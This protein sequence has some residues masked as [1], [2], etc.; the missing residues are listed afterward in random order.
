MKIG[1]YYYPEQWPRD[2]WERDF[3]LM[4]KMGLQIVH[5]GEFAWFDLEPSPGE[6]NFGW[7]DDCCRMAVERDMDIILC[8]PTAAPPIWASEQDRGVLPIDKAGRPYEHGGRRH[9]NP[10]SPGYR[11][12]TQRIVQ[13]LADHYGDH[14]RVIGWQIDNEFST[15]LHGGVGGFDQSE[16][17]RRAFQDWLRRKY[18]GDIAK[19]NAAWG[20]QFWTQHYRDFGEIYLPPSRERQ[21]GNP[22]HLLDA[23]RFWGWAHADYCKLQADILRPKIGERFI[24]HNFMPFHPDCD[25]A[26]FDT[27]LDLWAWDTYPADAMGGPYEDEVFRLPH[28]ARDEFIH[29]QMNAYN[30]RHALLEVQPGQI[31]WSGFPV[32]IYPGA[33]RLWLW[34]AFVHG[35]EMCT[36]YRFKQP[37]FHCEMHHHGLVE[38]DGETPSPGGRQFEQVAGEIEDLKAALPKM[39]DEYAPMRRDGDAEVA[40][41]FDFDQHWLYL[42]QPQANAWDY[43]GLATQWFAAFNRLGQDAAVLH[44]PKDRSPLQISE[45]TKVLVV[46]ALQMIDDGVLES[47]QAFAERGG[48]LILTC[49]TGHKDRTGQY[50]KVREGGKIAP[51]IGATIEAYDSMPRG[52]HGVVQLDGEDADHR[53]H[54]WADQLQPEA[55]TRTLATYADQF[56]EGA[57]AVTQRDLGEGTVTYCGV[58][59][60]GSLTQ[61]L[62]RRVAMAAGL[63]AVE[64]PEKVRL[65]RRGGVNVCLNHS[66]ESYTVKAGE[67]AKFVFG[68][69][70]VPPAGVSMWMDA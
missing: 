46:P 20:N 39:F 32:R 70:T 9:Y 26:D 29:E 60:E 11:E 25:P 8:T 61:S 14:E 5:M 23:S 4:A 6:F 57:V 21:H 63:E 48:H 68:D 56:Y 64:L 44:V 45:G 47:L 52:N 67:N 33:V 53:W 69:R 1:T 27:S 30:G 31:N 65:I 15:T 40:V 28:P 18:E 62:A 35:A 24:T 2:E 59:D 17:T 22:H 13:A 19:L 36:V 54:V 42:S 10:L 66:L 55:G 12:A 51:L 38:L 34:N 58:Y 49:R 37:R 50:F 16:V 41:L 43:P 3:D 7:L